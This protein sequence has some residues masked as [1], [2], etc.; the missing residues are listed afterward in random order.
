MLPVDRL[1]VIGRRTV[2]ECG[3]ATAAGVAGGRESVNSRARKGGGVPAGGRWGA[4]AG[5]LTDSVRAAGGRR[6]PR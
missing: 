3:S 6:V 4:G 1:L 2:L 5:D